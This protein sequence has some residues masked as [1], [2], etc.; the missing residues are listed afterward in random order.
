MKV[1][2]EEREWILNTI[3]RNIFRICN[4]NK[5][6]KCYIWGIFGDYLRSRVRDVRLNSLEIDYPILFAPSSLILFSLIA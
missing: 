4:F 1:L 6:T 3:H 2:T 5:E